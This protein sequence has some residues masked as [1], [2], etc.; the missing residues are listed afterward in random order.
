MKL[1]LYHDPG[2]AAPIG[3][4]VMPMRKFALVAEEL[5]KKARIRDLLST[6]CLR[7]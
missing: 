4:H 3:D 7:E 5:S 6:T 1:R 2:F